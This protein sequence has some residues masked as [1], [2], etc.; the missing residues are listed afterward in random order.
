VDLV[1]SRLVANSLRN[2]G[3]RPVFALTSAEVVKLLYGE[4]GEEDLV[5]LARRFS[6]VYREVGD[7]EIFT[8]VE[9]VG[10]LARYLNL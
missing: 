1:A 10:G 6:R 4:A 2:L 3:Y 8:V 7:L 9:D 5:A